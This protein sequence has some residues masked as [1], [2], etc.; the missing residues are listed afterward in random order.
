MAELICPICRKTL[1]RGRP[2]I[3]LVHPQ[4]LKPKKKDFIIKEA[5]VPDEKKQVE[6]LCFDTYGEIDFIEMGKWYD[7]RKMNN[8][9]ALKDKKVIGFA[10]WKKEKNRL[11]LL[12][13]LVEPNY[14]RLGVGTALLEKIKEIARKVKVKSILT[15][16][17]ND[18]LVSYV[19]YHLNGFRL[20][21]VDLRLPKKRHGKEEKGFW[22]LPC[23]DEFYL[24]CKL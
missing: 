15:P 22:G 16:I 4:C 21:G 8:L 11:F 1:K 17:S 24:E 18:D 9:V 2:F 6:K 14:L 3:G 12:V 7:V 5:S 13:V 20:S 10:S 23:R 19:F